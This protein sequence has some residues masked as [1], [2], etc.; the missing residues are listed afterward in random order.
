MCW[1][2]DPFANKVMREAADGRLR[3]SSSDGD[4]SVQSVDIGQA[5][6]VRG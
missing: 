2:G 5:L 6:G 3:R 1:D 4:R